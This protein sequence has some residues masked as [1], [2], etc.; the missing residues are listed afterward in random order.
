MQV[1][2]KRGLE[3]N[4]LDCMDIFL[5]QISSLDRPSSLDGLGQFGEADSVSHWYTTWNGWWKSSF[6]HSLIQLWALRIENIGPSTRFCYFPTWHHQVWLQQSRTH[7]QGHCL[8]N[9]FPLH[10]PMTKWN[11][12]L[13]DH[14]IQRLFVP[15]L[16]IPL[17]R[18]M[19]AIPFTQN[20]TNLDRLCFYPSEL[21]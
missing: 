11:S 6:V 7:S 15:W 19:F 18:N 20:S 16:A 8:V 17:S 10:R 13:S 21:Y 1:M 5:F 9:S 3:L 12:A 2:R 14:Q 4:R